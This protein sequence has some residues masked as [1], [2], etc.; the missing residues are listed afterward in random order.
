MGARKTRR[1]PPSVERGT[2]CGEGDALLEHRFLKRPAGRIGVRLE[3]EL[4]V[5]GPFRRGDSNPSVFADGNIVFL[6]EAQ[7]V[8]V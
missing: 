8:G 1:S 6:L 3:R 5:I 7:H 4:E 2:E